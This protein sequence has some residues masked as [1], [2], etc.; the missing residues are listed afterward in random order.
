MAS[1]FV[2]EGKY[3][4]MTAPSGG[5]ESGSTYKF[6]SLIVVALADADEG[7]AVECATSGVWTLA[8]TA[9]EAWTVGAK[10]YWDNTAGEWTTTTTSNTLAGYAHAAAASDAT[11]GQV[12]L[13]QM[14]G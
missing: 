12:Y 8:K 3:V 5:C 14:G 4:T 11:T 2:K 13:N 9:G 7:D 6:G 10:L 1:N